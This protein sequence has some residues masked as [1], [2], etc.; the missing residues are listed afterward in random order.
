MDFKYKINR[1][2]ILCFGTLVLLIT[3]L[4]AT[5]VVLEN[6]L[7]RTALC[8]IFI[9]GLFLMFFAQL[10]ITE[11]SIKNK[12][13]FFPFC[14]KIRECKFDEI[15]KIT[16]DFVIL[17]EAGSFKLHPWDDDV[18]KTVVINFLTNNKKEIIQKILEKRPDLKLNDWVWD[19]VL[20]YKIVRKKFLI[21]SS[22]IILICI[23][24]SIVQ[25]IQR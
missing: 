19:R 9:Y 13:V 2:F 14:S 21:V 6:K 7:G 20:N 25:H 10:I 12:I 11:N 5:D 18:N 24:I 23:L 15:R 8:V 16:Y 3:Y 1:I 17:E 4:T 22:V